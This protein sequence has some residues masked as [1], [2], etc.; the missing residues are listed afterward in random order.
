[1]FFPS[2]GVPPS[3][4]FSGVAVPDPCLP[5]PFLEINF[6]FLPYWIPRSAPPLEVTLLSV[7]GSPRSHLPFSS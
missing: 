6:R 1:M 4:K 3:V 2:L 5:L 7:A